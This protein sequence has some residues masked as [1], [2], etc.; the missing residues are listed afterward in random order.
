MQCLRCASISNLHHAAVRSADFLLLQ[1][2]RERG[3]GAALGVVEQLVEVLGADADRQHAVL[4]T[5]VVENVAERGRDHAADAEIHQRPGR[6]LAARAAAEIVAGDQDLGLAIGRL[7][8]HEIR[9]LA[10]VVLVAH[11]GKQALAEPSAFD[12]LQVLLGDDH[13][14]VDIDHLHRR[15]D[16]FQGGEL[17]HRTLVLRSGQS[18]FMAACA[19]PV[20][21]RHRSCRC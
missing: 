19:P 12:G 8:E 4:E 20:K 16:A 21:R 7:V 15:G 2:D 17:F 13:V 9:V 3:I 14:G 6:V 10:A 5:V 1:I 18:E 11:L